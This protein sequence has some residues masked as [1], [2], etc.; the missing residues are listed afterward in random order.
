MKSKKTYFWIL[1]LPYCRQNR[2]KGSRYQKKNF[3]K[4]ILFSLVNLSL[5]FLMSSKETQQSKKLRLNPE[6][7]VT[8]MINSKNQSQSTFLTPFLEEEIVFKFLFRIQKKN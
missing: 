4:W 7:R 8:K 2:E 5:R 3:I 6:E 1:L